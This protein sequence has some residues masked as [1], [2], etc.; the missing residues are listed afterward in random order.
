MI[1]LL[2]LINSLAADFSSSERFCFLGQKVWDLESSI[3]FKVMKASRKGLPGGGFLE[4]SDLNTF[5]KEISF[6]KML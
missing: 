1:I 5:E 2:S 6:S 3:S 4:V